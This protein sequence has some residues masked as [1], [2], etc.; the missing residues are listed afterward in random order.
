MAAEG[1]AS[2]TAANSSQG[3]GTGAL[4]RLVRTLSGNKTT[5][6]PISPV[7]TSGIVPPSIS[8]THGEPTHHLPTDTGP[9]PT[10]KAP[11]TK[12]KVLFAGVIDRLK[13]LSFGLGKSSD[14][15][16][17]S[18]SAPPGPRNV[19]SCALPP[20]AET[21]ASIPIPSPPEPSTVE[22]DLVAFPSADTT[23]T[24]ADPAEPTYLARKIQSL[25]DALPLPRGPA[26]SPPPKKPPKPPA[27]DRT[28][29][30]IPPPGATPIKDTK[31][32]AMLSSAT[33]MN[34]GH[35]WDDRRERRVSVWS[36]LES[37]GS[38]RGE[39]G[40]DHDAEDA[41][42]EGSGDGGGEGEGDGG[43]VFSDTSGIM[44][45]SPLLPT[46]DSL[47]EIAESGVVSPSPP[48]PLELQD[49]AAAQQL[50]GWM[51]MWPFSMWGG[52]G[53]GSTATSTSTLVPA[54]AARSPVP[55]VAALVSPAGSPRRA[56]SPPLPGSPR[57]ARLRIQAQ[58]VWVP[59]TTKLSVQVMWWGYRLYLP[60]PVLDVLDDKQVEATKRAALIT[61]AL[62]WFFSHIPAE[63]LPPAVRPAVLLLQTLVPYV[64]YIGTFISWS[65]GT[66]K[67]YDTGYGVILT[68]TWLLP[69]A[70]IPGTWE[71]RDFPPPSPPEQTP[72]P[73]PAPSSP[74]PA[75][76][77]PAPAPTT[78]A[79]APPSPLP[80][81]PPPPAPSPPTSTSPPPPPQSPRPQPQPP[82]TSLPSPPQ[83]P[84]TPAQ[85]AR[86]PPPS[87][88]PTPSSLPLPV[89]LAG[90][91]DPLPPWVPPPPP[92][93]PP[94]I[95]LPDLG[96][97]EEEAEAEVE[98][99][100]AVVERR[101]G[102]GALKVTRRSS[103]RGGEDKSGERKKGKGKGKG[104][105]RLK[106]MVMGAAGAA[107]KS[108]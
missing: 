33:I 31:L 40:N 53:A 93:S 2:S 97:E 28:G 67:S 30:P 11:S 13:N 59:S 5:S 105:A 81:P 76:P 106:A 100:A 20:I 73:L 95:P 49:S 25:I 94:K 17:D 41:P 47:V 70:L 58:R 16:H 29:R 90:P 26:P 57:S 44:M 15:E 83:T 78:P 45:Y 54:A 84:Q 23:D 104:K 37:L 22:A 108:G 87:S 48:A 8:E 32:I 91:S 38:T 6:Q 66:I 64:G 7:L 74:P 10:P 92:P 85:P 34:G 18:V 102:F 98:V 21:S 63:A 24:D 82:T 19:S 69:V 42:G 14:A 68:A 86:S 72:S 75:S 62:T 88:T 52:G 80:L 56:G 46:N 35:V 50:A 43:S 79:P 107:S 99:E 65:W 77:P 101:F 61:T 27:R 103:G 51:G 96:P 55:S 39:E 1:A 3:S 12:E 4:H 9:S 89:V 60:P 71:A 36:V